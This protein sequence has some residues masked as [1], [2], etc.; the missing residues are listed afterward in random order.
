MSTLAWIVVFGLAMS[1]LALIGGVTTLLS[2]QALARVLLPLVALAAGSLL[3]GAFFHILPQAVEQ[4]GNEL[5]VYVSFVAG[6]A[7]FFLLEQYLHWHHCHR[8]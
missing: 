8:R 6:F 3:G 1:A 5:S 2:E 7:A 4:S